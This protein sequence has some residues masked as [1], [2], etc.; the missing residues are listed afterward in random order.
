MKILVTQMKTERRES[1]RL[2]WTAVRKQ[3]HKYNPVY[4]VLVRSY[5]KKVTGEATRDGQREEIE[6]TNG[7]DEKNGGHNKDR[8]VSCLVEAIKD[9]FVAT[10]EIVTRN[11]MNNRQD[12]LN[13][14]IYIQ[15]SV[16]T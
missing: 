9:V 14:N 2:L 16:F 11:V 15:F 4:H 6:E 7:Q 8:A 10:V 12:E 1:R 13:Q 3:T 5:L